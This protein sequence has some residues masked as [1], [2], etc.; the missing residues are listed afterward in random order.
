[1]SSRVRSLRNVSYHVESS[2]IA[3][4]HVMLCHVA[5]RYVLSRRVQRAAVALPTNA[6]LRFTQLT[7]TPRVLT[8]LLLAKLTL[9]PITFTP[10]TICLRRLPA[11]YVFHLNLRYG[12][13]RSGRISFV[14]LLAWHCV[15][16]RA[17]GPGRAWL[18]RN[19]STLVQ[20][21]AQKSFPKFRSNFVS[22]F[23]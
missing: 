23:R 15:E 18:R 7:L 22:K 11:T 21:I 16:V 6:P 4:R 2:R 1:M 19:T 10:T 20:Y 9:I 5:S 14:V 13:I 3:S 17:K 12:I 8:P